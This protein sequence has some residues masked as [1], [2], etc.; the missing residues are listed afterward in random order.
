MHGGTTAD[1]SRS[2]AGR[3]GQCPQCSTNASASNPACGRMTK[4]QKAQIEKTNGYELLR[5]RPH[6][7]AWHL[8]V[9]TSRA[10]EWQR[11]GPHNSLSILRLHMVEKAPQS[12]PGVHGRERKAER[13][14]DC[15]GAAMF[16]ARVFPTVRQPKPVS[17]EKKWQSLKSLLCQRENNGTKSAKKNHNA[18]NE[19]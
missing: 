11:G 16:R 10:G 14:K 5:T 8:R 9:D 18:Q 15:N 13:Q 12:R 4:K 17:R 3:S 19:L 7:L 2:S 1:K 6:R